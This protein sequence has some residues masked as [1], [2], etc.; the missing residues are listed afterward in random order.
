MI[1]IQDSFPLPYKTL[2]KR[3]FDEDEDALRGASP[4]THLEG[5]S[6]VPPALV[7]YTNWK[8]TETDSQWLIDALR[9]VGAPFEVFYVQDKTHDTVSRDVGKPGDV[10]PAEILRFLENIGS[11]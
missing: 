10:V 6:Y 5:G 4:V 7:I 2:F 3:V 1:N 9:E 11:G 8:L